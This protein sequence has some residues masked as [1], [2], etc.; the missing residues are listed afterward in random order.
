M[1]V[2]VC[3]CKSGRTLTLSIHH[4]HHHHHHHLVQLSVYPESEGIKLRLFLC[5]IVAQSVNLSLLRGQHLRLRLHAQFLL[6]RS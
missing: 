3:N 1:L 2:T 5:Q 4:H 6:I